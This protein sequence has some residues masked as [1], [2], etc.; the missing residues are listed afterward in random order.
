MTIQIQGGRPPVQETQSG[1]HRLVAASERAL[2]HN[3]PAVLVFFLL[4]SLVLGY[5]ALMVRPDA[6]FSRMIPTGHSFIANYLKFEE[7]LRAQSN[8]LRVVVENPSGEILTKGFLQTLQEATDRIFYI[9]GVDRG[10]LKSLWTPNALWAEVTTE[11][12]RS[13]R[14]IPD[15]YDGSPEALAQV[16]QNIQRANMVGSFVATDFRSAIIRVP[17]L[18]RNPQ[19]GEPLDYGAFSKA[20]ETRGAR[21][22]CRSGCECAGDRLCADHR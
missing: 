9:P 1:L 14:V 4:V 3:R 8:V 18:E 5:F 11:G 12:L 15:T 6:S 21:P 22:F 20:L 2:F 13:G 7:V 16:R 10:N 17:L 19:T